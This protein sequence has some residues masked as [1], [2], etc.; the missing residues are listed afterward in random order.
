MSVAGRPCL[1]LAEEREPAKLDMGTLQ[2]EVVKE[3]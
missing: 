2:E 1:T 3:K